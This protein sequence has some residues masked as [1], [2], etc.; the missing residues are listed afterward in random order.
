MRA[1]RGVSFASDVWTRP[2][3]DDMRIQSSTVTSSAKMKRVSKSESP[4]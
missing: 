3:A 1:Q 4:G 2:T